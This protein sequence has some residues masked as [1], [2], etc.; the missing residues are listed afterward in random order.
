MVTGSPILE[1]LQ[2]AAQRRRQQQRSSQPSTSHGTHEMQITHQSEDAQSQSTSIPAHSTRAHRVHHVLPISTRAEI[3]KW[4][5]SH[6]ADSTDGEKHIASKAVRNFPGHFRGT[7]NANITRAQR[8][9]KERLD[10]QSA[11]GTISLR[12]S[13]ACISRI[14]KHGPKRVL[15]KAR[16]GRGRRRQVW[17]DALHQDLRSEFDRL[18][19]L[20]VKF[21]FNTLRYLA[22]H[23]LHNTE[24]TD[25][26]ANMPDP[27][28][29]M[30]LHLKIDLRWIQTFTERFNIISRT[31][32][33]KCRMSPAKEMEIEIAV[34]SH[35]GTMCG[36]LTSGKVDESNLENADETHFIINVDNGKTLGFSGCDD[37]KYADVVSG[38]EGFTMVVRLSGGKQARVEPP[39]LVFVNK[40]RNYPIRGTPDCIEGVAYRTGPKGWMDAKIMPLWLSETR[41]I[42]PLSNGRERSLYV[43]N[44]S[45]H[46]DTPQLREAAEKIRTVIKYF[47][48]NATHLIQPCDSFVIQKIKQRWSS[49]WETF[50][51]DMIRAGKWKDG[52]GRLHNPGKTF[53][54]K[55]AAK[56]VREVNLQRDGDG[57]SYARK[58]MIITG[59]ALNSNG[60]WEPSQLRPELQVIIS[61]HRSVFD[62]SRSSAMGPQ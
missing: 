48:P 47:P 60:I 9:W 21:N 7:N 36:L 45:G 18:R 38:G 40:N 24:N 6:V 30:P 44:C 57:I 20:G 32:K 27:L 16:A 4:M 12:G 8:L 17:V 55:L 31:H 25:Y 33:G 34:A 23:L 43:D 28:S 56:C 29:Q 13:T 11:D 5:V 41:V 15:L 39:F 59:M 62:S 49:H 51:M 54:L 2:R 42:R 35:L 26:S 52:S 19:R 14:T 1:C 53:F 50:K 46:N 10:Y 61:K 37:V 3:V 58:A 22:L